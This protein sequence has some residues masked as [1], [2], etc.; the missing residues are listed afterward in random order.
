[1]YILLY[2]LTHRTA[3]LRDVFE[4][5]LVRNG[6]YRSI[7]LSYTEKKIRNA[8]TVEYCRCKIEHGHGFLSDIPDNAPIMNV[9]SPK[10]IAYCAHVDSSDALYF[11]PE[12]FAS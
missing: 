1:M 7:S 6:G 5:Q 9:H 4:M 8:Y 11:T 2:A 3:R 12:I 10:R